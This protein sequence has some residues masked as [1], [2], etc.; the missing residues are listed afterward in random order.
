VLLQ[1]QQSQH[2]QEKIIFFI[3]MAVEI[4]QHRYNNLISWFYDIDKL[5]MPNQSTIFV[6]YKKLSCSQTKYRKSKKSGIIR[7]IFLVI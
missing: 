3:T 6:S 5:E 4:Y 7:R 1:I 2:Y